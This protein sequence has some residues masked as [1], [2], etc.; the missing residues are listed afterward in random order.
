MEDVELG[1]EDEEQD[2]V[3]M[4][5]DNDDPVGDAKLHAV[6]PTGVFSIRIGFNMWSMCGAGR[7]LVGDK[8]RDRRNSLSFLSFD[9]QS[10]SEFLIKVDGVTRFF[11]LF[12]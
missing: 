8:R 1:D 9:S 6:F 2:A 11:S 7:N 10:Y 12:K 5:V 3:D 4:S